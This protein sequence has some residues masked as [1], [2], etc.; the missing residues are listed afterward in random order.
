MAQP[1]VCPICLNWDESKSNFSRNRDGYLVQCETCGNFNISELAWEDFL[2]PNVPAGKKLTRVQRSRLSHRVQ[3]AQRASSSK[4]PEM[5]ADYVEKF[6]QSGCP[7]PTPAE[8]AVNLLSY[9][10]G[11]ISKNGYSVSSLPRNIHAIVGSPNTAAVSLLITELMQ[12]G[13]L[14]GS[15]ISGGNANGL[16]ADIHMKLAGWQAYETEKSGKFAGKYGF[17]AMKFGDPVLDPFVQ[18]HVK[19]TI[20]S[21][22]GFYLI[23][24]RD[25]AQAGIIDNIMRAQIRDSA[26]VLVDLTHDNAG[27][28]W[29]AG[30]AEGLGK[31]VI[32]LCEKSK[33]DKAKTHFDTNHCTTV[34]WDIEN[35]QQFKN[36][37]IAT[38]RRSLNLFE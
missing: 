32:Y 28:Y 29:E 36:E 6:I 34:I 22:I 21:G 11:E 19:P 12:Q 3:A 38:L 17:I 18:N 9:I 31:P 15:G 14:S 30:Y 10:G 13:L 23:D 26:F 33:F 2:D 37:L 4:W 25:V 16:T 20:R 1:N 24:V 8:Q 5:N 27:A 7:G 35:V